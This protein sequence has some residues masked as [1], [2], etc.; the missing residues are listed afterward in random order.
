MDPRLG[1]QL[2]HNFSPHLQLLS[3]LVYS[4][5]EDQQDLEHR[6]FRQGPA[7][8][9]KMLLTCGKM[10]VLACLVTD[11]KRVP[12]ILCLKLVFL[13]IAKARTSGSGLIK[14]SFPSVLNCASSAC[15]RGSF[16]ISFSFYLFSLV[17]LLL[18][19]PLNLWTYVVARGAI[20][21]IR[22]RLSSVTL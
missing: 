20:F 9:K 14:A 8:E 11:V 10:T 6:S 12:L 7:G 2:F 3:F 15:R 18:L 13:R 16:M 4:L 17:R 19:T 21:S 1:S 22:G 5:P